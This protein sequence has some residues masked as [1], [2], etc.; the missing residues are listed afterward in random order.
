VPDHLKID[1]IEDQAHK[2][3]LHNLKTEEREKDSYDFIQGPESSITRDLLEKIALL[4]QPQKRS[5]LE[6][7]VLLDTH[8]K[9]QMCA[10]RLGQ[11]LIDRGIQPFINQENGGPKSNINLFE[12]R[13][14]QVSVLIIFYGSVAEEWIRERINSVLQFAAKQIINTKQCT[15]KSCG[16]VLTPPQKSVEAIHLEQSLFRI[17]LIDNSQCDDI[18]AKLLTPLFEDL[19]W[20]VKL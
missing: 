2:N 12:E 9:D 17:H 5:P 4:K 6:C 13:L 10:F 20:G 19:N 11:Y 15:L 3:F 14:K 18:D 7:S 8:L 1:N 16:I